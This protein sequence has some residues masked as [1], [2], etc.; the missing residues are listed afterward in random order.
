[1]CQGMH[2]VMRWRVPGFQFVVVGDKACLYGGT[3]RR[4]H[5]DDLEVEGRRVEARGLGQVARVKV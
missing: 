1:M 3:Y 4:G 2:D 5:D